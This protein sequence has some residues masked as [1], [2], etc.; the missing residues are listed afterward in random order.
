MLPGGICEV[1]TP[2]KVTNL[3]NS[4]LQILHFLKD[5]KPLARRA[6][7]ASADDELIT[8]I[9]GCAIKTLNGNH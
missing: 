7:L 4:Q 8:A 2:V 6:L 5:A 1:F 9:V 3:L